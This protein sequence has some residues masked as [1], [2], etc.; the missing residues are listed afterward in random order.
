MASVRLG[1]CALKGKLKG[2]SKCPLCEVQQSRLKDPMRSIVALVV[3]LQ[4]KK[5][6]LKLD[7]I[8]PFKDNKGDLEEKNDV[9]GHRYLSSAADCLQSFCFHLEVELGL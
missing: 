1:F 2:Q 8:S 4:M 5:K 7:L 9:T 6:T 3:F